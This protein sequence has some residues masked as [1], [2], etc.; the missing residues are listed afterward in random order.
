MGKLM[1]LAAGALLVLV[2][3][4]KRK[5]GM[6]AKGAMPAAASQIA[7]GAGSMAGRGANALFGIGLA[8]IPPAAAIP[9]SAVRA[10][11]TTVKAGG[12][13]LNL[14]RGTAGGVVHTATF[15]LL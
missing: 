2:V 1:L 5:A 4:R 15:G 6:P 13:L 11:T 14:A 9:T 8:A 3:I 12:S 10:A 7:G